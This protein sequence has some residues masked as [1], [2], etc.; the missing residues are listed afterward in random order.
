M[1]ANNIRSYCLENQIELN[2]LLAS[3]FDDENFDFVV[4]IVSHAVNLARAGTPGAHD[5]IAGLAQSDDTNLESARYFENLLTEA[6]AAWF[7]ETHQE[8]RIAAIE[9]KSHVLR[10]PH[11]RNPGKSCDLMAEMRGKIAYFEVKDC[12]IDFLPS[13]TTGSRGYTPASDKAK[14]R[15]LEKQVRE[16]LNKGA[17]Y[18]LARLPVWESSS[19]AGLDAI[20]QVLCEH[21]MIQ[22]NHARINVPFSVPD[23]FRGIF[24]IK[25]NGHVFVS[26]TETLNL[27]TNQ[28]QPS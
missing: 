19:C 20:R 11:A 5:L 2:G 15:W 1:N 21:R 18:L 28:E 27:N 17:N 25:R 16:C 26:V 13:R 4:Q 22:T 23:W 8:A 10:S 24:L 12:S 9:S 7:L 3:T 14:R 6:F